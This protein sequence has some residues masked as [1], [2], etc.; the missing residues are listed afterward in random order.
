[1][2]KTQFKEAF[3]RGLGS[4]YLEL[5]ACNSREKYKDI[6]LW[7]CLHDTCYDM[8]CEGGRGI[9]LYNAIC[10]FDD[11]SFFED[12][13]IG[14][15]MKMKLDTWV[16]DQLCELLYLFASDG[17]VKARNAL[18]EKYNQLLAVLS[19]KRRSSGIWHERDNFE[20]LCVWL[21]SLDGFRA[22]KKIVEQVGEYYLKSNETNTF[23]LDWFYYN[24]KNKFGQKRVDNY[25]QKNAIKSMAVKAFFKEVE[26]FAVHKVSEPVVPT[27]KELIEACRESSA[28]IG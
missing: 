17:S 2:T 10:L 28:S 23:Y 7:C 27:L 19:K 8:Q 9:Y 6:V 12:K 11:K 14:H 18:Y 25:L 1:M 13:I 4:A 21:T 5:K 24:S 20:W 22:Y 16:F 26:S 3:K 15:F